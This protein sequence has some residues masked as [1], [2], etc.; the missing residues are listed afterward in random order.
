MIRR[1]GIRLFNITYFDG[2][3]GPL[4]DSADRKLRIKYDPRN[5]GAVFIELPAGG[6]LRVPYADLARPPISLWELR[7]ATRAIRETG[8]QGIDETAV[9]TAIDEQRR[10]IAEALTRSKAARRA[11]TKQPNGRTVQ[12][13][14]EALKAPQEVEP[15][16]TADEEHGRVPTVSDND[17]WKTEFLA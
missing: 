3:L 17:A 14:T 5:L 12:S 1:E 9:F 11:S 4:L 6:H 13:V 7:A 16:D 2:A 8:R 15:R 10:L